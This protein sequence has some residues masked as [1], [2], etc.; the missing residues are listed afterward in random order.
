MDEKVA[1]LCCYCAVEKP[2]YRAVFDVTRPT[3]GKT[4][5]F[6]AGKALASLVPYLLGTANAKPKPMGD[7]LREQLMTIPW[8]PRWL[9]ELTVQR[10]AGPKGPIPDLQEQVRLLAQAYPTERPKAKEVITVTR[11]NGM[12]FQLNGHRL[13]KKV[14]P[15]VWGG[16]TQHSKIDEKHKRLLM[17]LAWARDWIR[18]GTHRRRVSKLRKAFPIDMKVKLLV[19]F[20]TTK[21]DGS[22]A[23][24]P[25]WKDSIPQRCPEAFG[26]G[27]W[28]FR[29]AWWLDDLAENWTPNGRPGVVLNAEQKRAVEALPWFTAWVED[30]RA[31]RAKRAAKKLRA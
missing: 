10:L 22:P 20:Y 21:P 28:N 17:S 16:A 5:S 8:L 18:Q 29:A 6:K 15:N 30:V 14:A 25:S 11:D 9:E 12:T 2:A 3:N 23:E 1:L 19:K 26:G 24:R 4:I 13:L 27:I 31:S 7:D